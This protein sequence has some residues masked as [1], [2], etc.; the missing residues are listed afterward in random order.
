[1]KEQELQNLLNKGLSFSFENNSYRNS[2]GV[3]SKAT[4]ELLSWIT[5]VDH[6]I[7]TNYGHDSS[8]YQLFK[9]LDQGKLNGWN[10]S[11][12]EK[13]LTIIRGAL[14]GC[15][16]ITP[17]RTKKTDD[18]LILQLIK[19][20]VFWPTIVVLIGAAFSLGHYFGQSNF[21]K[22]KQD[23]YDLSKKQAT[24]FDL[25]KSRKSI[26]DST[27]NTLKIQNQQLADSL[28]RINTNVK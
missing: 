22:E 10:K 9:S 18:S 7:S 24:E 25:I 3:Y 21:D 23:L 26:Q 14:K 6:Y 17:V 4:D 2:N 20:I 28:E 27:L 16:G 12:L 11:D 1:M 5:E 8:P 15:R 19:N 13:Q